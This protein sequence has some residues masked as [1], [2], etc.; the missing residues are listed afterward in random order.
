MEKYNVTTLGVPGGGG[1]Y[2]VQEGFGWTNAVVMKLLDTYPRTILT[3]P[4]TRYGK[5]FQYFPQINVRSQAKSY[6]QVK[7]CT[8]VI[9]TIITIDYFI[10][11]RRWLQPC[12]TFGVV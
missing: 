5:F 9:V 6:F 11:N 8:G 3:F 7:K 12:T 1:E 4:N 2:P 10:L